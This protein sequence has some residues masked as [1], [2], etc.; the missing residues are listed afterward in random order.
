MKGVLIIND[1]SPIHIEATNLAA[2][3]AE[4][5]A[6]VEKHIPYYKF[7]V[8]RAGVFF[9]VIQFHSNN[10]DGAV[11]AELLVKGDDDDF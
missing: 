1:G 5:K 4:G 8:T 9:N 2:L 10:A 7:A 3:V 6:I 11:M